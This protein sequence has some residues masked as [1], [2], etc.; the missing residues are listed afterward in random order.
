MNEGLGTTWRWL[1]NDRIFILGW[2]NSLK[3]CMLISK[4]KLSP[5]FW[6]VLYSIYDCY[7]FNIIGYYYTNIISDIILLLLFY[8]DLIFTVFMVCPP[9]DLHKIWEMLHVQL[10]SGWKPLVDDFKRRNRKWAGNHAGYSTGWVLTGLG[11]HRWAIN[12]NR[13]QWCVSH[14]LFTVEDL[15]FYSYY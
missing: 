14:P 6:I 3:L 12:Q 7:I 8:C 13:H 11:W 5:T 10:R 2:T 4:K 15:S 1:I 9:T